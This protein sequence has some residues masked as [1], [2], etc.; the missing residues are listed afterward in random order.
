MACCSACTARWW[1]DGYD[2]CE[3]DILEHVRAM[4]GPQVPIGVELDPHCHLTEK[5]VRLANA[6][7][8]Y[9][10]YPHIDF[11]ER[12][13]E[14]RR[15][16]RCRTIRGEI[17]P[18]MS[19]FDCR[20]IDLVPTTREPGRS[21]V[22]R[23]SALEG[24]ESVLSVSLA[25]GFQQGDVPEI[26]SR[27][28]VITDDAKAAGDAL[29]TRLGEE[30]RAL[31]GRFAPPVV[32]LDEALDQA[33]ASTGNRPER[34]RRFDRQRRRRRGPDNTNIIH[35]LRERGIRDVAIGPVWDPVAVGFCLTAGVGATIPL[36]FGGKAAATSGTPVD[37]EVTVL[38]AVRNGTQSFGTAKVPIGDA[39]GIRI[40]GID[41]A[42][43][44]HRTQALGLEIF[45]SVGIDPTLKRI[46]SVK[47]TNHFHAAYGPI[48]SAVIYTD[49]GGPSHLD[50]RKYPYRKIAR[51][52]W[53]HD[54]LPPGR[55][56]V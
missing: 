4:V 36:R 31:E 2:D 44:S 53:P 1:R 22:D 14:L 37:G 19:L 49:G 15:P 9:K 52:L 32:P 17:K 38:G 7:I 46:V 3:G 27:V 8:L 42:L 55:M 30:F 10:E 28:L 56:V 18:V 6:I 29:A 5:R 33:L 50:V 11:V 21:F 25:H 41:V 39:V 51:P 20:M 45:T 23:M 35:R 26:G 47:S 24:K 43:L 12:A 40:D 54:P 34:H 48:A 13:E 16:H